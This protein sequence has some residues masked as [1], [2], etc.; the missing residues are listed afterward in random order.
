MVR[1]ERTVSNIPE[2]T[3]RRIPIVAVISEGDRE[4]VDDTPHILSLPSAPGLLQ[5]ILEV[6]PLQMLAYHIG[7][8]RGYDVDRPRNLSK[9]V[10]VE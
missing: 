9:S 1:Y 5:P 6:I 2:F 4:I 7:A 3:E 10:L 8:L